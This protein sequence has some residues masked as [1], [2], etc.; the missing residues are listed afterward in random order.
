MQCVLCGHAET[1]VVDSRLSSDGAS[2][3]RRRECLKCA[4]RFSTLE[5]V[6]LLGLS[7]VKRD[8]RREQYSREKVV[9]GLK[10]ALEKRPYTEE[11]FNQLVKSVERDIQKKSQGEI[12][13]A[14]IGELL[15]KRLR[16]F[17]KVAYIRFASVY[18][19]FEDVEMFERALRELSK[20][21][22]QKKVRS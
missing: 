14:Q 10:K 21:R 18:Q 22:R 5:E 4:F 3:R 11:Q 16:Q 17:D 20:R 15:M 8:G 1:K 9:H 7:V 13:S 2:I 6:E 12:T 19:S